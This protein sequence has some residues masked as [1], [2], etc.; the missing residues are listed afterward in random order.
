MTPSLSHLPSIHQMDWRNRPVS[1]LWLRSILQVRISIKYGQTYLHLA[2]QH[3][4]TINMTWHIYLL[5]HITY[6]SLYYILLHCFISTWHTFTIGTYTICVSKLRTLST[7]SVETC[8]TFA[9]KMTM[10]HL[11]TLNNAKIKPI[12]IHHKSLVPNR[13]NPYLGPGYF[14]LKSKDCMPL[15]VKATMMRRG[16]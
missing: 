5:S 13:F 3:L 7:F 2:W 15:A 16:M 8:T 6:N 1:D 12:P 11:K 4:G 10:N 9:T 14:L